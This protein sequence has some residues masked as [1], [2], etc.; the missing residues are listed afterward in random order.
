MKGGS[1]RIL[2]VLPCYNERHTIADV[3]KRLSELPIVCDA[4]VIDDGSTDD[5]AAVASPYAICVRLLENLGIGGAV[6]TGIMY[7]ERN[8]YDICIQVDGDGQHLPEEL[9]K[10]LDIWRSQRANLV[11]GSRYK[12]NGEFR[13]TWQRRLGSQIIGKLLRLLFGSRDITDCTSG[14][15]LLDRRAIAFFSKRYPSDFPEPIS[16]AWALR[17]RL[18][19]I[20]VPVV[21]RA[22]ES[23]KSSISGFKT[24]SYMFRVIFYIC[25]ARGQKRVKEQP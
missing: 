2:I 6:Q 13:S 15:R 9:H 16:L 10:L 19:V 24:L 17:N 5:T 20:E 8:G 11:I 18:E 12:G 7:A 22:R 1:E 25:L 3:L 23:G 14:F 4:L 21:M